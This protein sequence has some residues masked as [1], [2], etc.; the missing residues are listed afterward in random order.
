MEDHRS[1]RDPIPSKYLFINFINNSQ[2]SGVKEIGDQKHPSINGQFTYRRFESFLCFVSRAQFRSF[3][4]Q[5][6][7]GI[8]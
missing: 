3:V 8:H 1:T 6:L 4:C 7:L 2:F 5:D